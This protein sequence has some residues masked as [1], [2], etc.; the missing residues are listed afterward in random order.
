M[1]IYGNS[2]RE[3]LIR[4]L[5]VPISMAIIPFYVY[6]THYEYSSDRQPIYS[7]AT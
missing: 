1:D 6:H 2:Y 5:F 3:L 4:S 7:F